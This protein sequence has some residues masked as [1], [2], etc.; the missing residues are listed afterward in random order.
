[1]PLVPCHFGLPISS[2][3]LWLKVPFCWLLKMTYNVEID[4]FFVRAF[5][6]FGTWRLIVGN[7][8]LFKMSFGWN[9]SDNPCESYAL[10]NFSWLF[11]LSK[12]SNFCIFDDFWAKF[13][14]SWPSIDQMMLVASKWY[15]DQKFELLT[16]KWPFCPYSWL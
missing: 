5:L 3:G 9:F 8:F 6:G 11:Q 4:N 10:V 16:V 13:W 15:V 2:Y 1:M 12:Y 14:E 7:V